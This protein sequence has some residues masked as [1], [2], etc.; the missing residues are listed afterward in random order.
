MASDILE[1]EA[2]EGPGPQKVAEVPGSANQILTPH[3]DS[4]ILGVCVFNHTELLTAF[5]PDPESFL[6][7]RH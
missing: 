2:S 6:L 1:S 5:Y 7:K 3:A 4:A